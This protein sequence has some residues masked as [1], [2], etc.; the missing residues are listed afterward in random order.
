MPDQKPIR[1]FTVCDEIN[2]K[3][4]VKVFNAIVNLKTDPPEPKPFRGEIMY[5]QNDIVVIEESPGLFRAK[6]DGDF[7]DFH[8]C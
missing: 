6:I 8:P 2:N 3:Y 5:I 1:T 7:K 4:E